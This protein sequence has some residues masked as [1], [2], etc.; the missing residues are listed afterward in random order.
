MGGGV[1]ACEETSIAKTVNGTE[2]YP[3][4]QFQDLY[5]HAWKSGLKGLATYRPNK[6]LGSVLQVDKPQDFVSDDVNRRITVKSVPAPVL[7]SLRWPGRP[8]LPGG[9]PSWTY[10]IEHPQSRFAVFVSHIENGHPHAFEVWVN[11][12]EQPRGI[13]ALAKTLSMDMR[14]KDLAW[15]RLKL[16][17]LAKAGGDPFDLPFPP[18]GEKKRMPSLV[19]A[20]AQI[21]RWRIQ[22]LASGPTEEAFSLRAEQ[23]DSPIIDAMFALKEPKT[24]T[25]GTLSWTIDILNPR[26]GDDFVLGLKEITLPDG[27]T[28]PYSV[29]LSGE[30]PRAL[31]G[32]CKLL[33]LDM[34]VVD[35]AWIGM[36]LRKLL[37]LPEALGD[38][39][40]VTPGTR[41]Q[42]NW[43]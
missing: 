17:A 30:Y 29:W 43:P 38:F 11:G 14:A 26:S 15:L 42:Q 16:D 37:D 22:Q 10:M 9:N 8:E 34:R 27:I 25:D 33:S 35:P 23:G 13:G 24:G 36:K 19:A 7:S 32:L 31:D 5:M 2:D 1:G 6:V 39:M 21:V 41:R 12:S 4:G 28:R 3:Y 20:F 40:A 18:A